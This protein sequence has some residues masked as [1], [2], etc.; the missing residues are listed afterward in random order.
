MADAKVRGYAVLW[1]ELSENLG[2]FR[3]RFRRGAFTESLAD[4]Q[5]KFMV[6]SHDLARPVA[7]TS[8]GT[9]TLSEDAVGL[10]F[11]AKLPDSGDAGDL[12]AMVRRRVLTQMSF[13]FATERAADESFTEENGELIRTIRKARLFEV[14]PVTF[15]AYPQT[16]VQARSMADDVTEREKALTKAQQRERERDLK[17]RRLKTAQ[18]AIEASQKP[19]PESLERIKARASRKRVAMARR[20]GQ[21]V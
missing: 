14:S 19:P 10:R 9:L 12:A 11:E 13:A 15:P 7:S 5:V 6:R 1:D 4:D 18:A 2:G 16:S 17:R 8:S 21:T 20:F 3:E